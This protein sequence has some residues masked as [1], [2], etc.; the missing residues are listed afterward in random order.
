MKKILPIILCVLISL[1][2]LSACN[3]RQDSYVPTGNAL[4][5]EA[6]P[7]SATEPRDQ[8]LTLTYYRE[9]SLNPLTCSDFTNRTIM[10][11]L[12]QGLFTVDRNYKV[13]PV[14]P[15]SPGQ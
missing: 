11:L 3:N 2:V 14:L 4:G 6:T 10:P 1:F 12:Y 5:E 7:P 13:E 15:L 9:K 8:L